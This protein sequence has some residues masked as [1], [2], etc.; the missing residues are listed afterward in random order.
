MGQRRCVTVGLIG[1][2]DYGDAIGHVATE[3]ALGS[4]RLAVL[5]DDLVSG[6]F[7]IDVRVERRD[8][9]YTARATGAW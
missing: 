6:C 7:G 1:Q 9:R 2:N 5:L 4:R 8:G 3:V